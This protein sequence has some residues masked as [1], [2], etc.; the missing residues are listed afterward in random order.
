MEF[1]PL[2]DTLTDTIRWWAE[3]DSINRELAGKL[4]PPAR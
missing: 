2:R 3:H 1:R 4:A